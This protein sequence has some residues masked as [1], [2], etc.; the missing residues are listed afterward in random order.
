MCSSS[1]EDT[2]I[3]LHR[4]TIVQSVWVVNMNWVFQAVS[5]SDGK[6]FLDNDRPV[7]ASIK[8]YFHLL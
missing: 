3:E 5:E 7:G 6:K 2:R 1:A 4:E 8:Y